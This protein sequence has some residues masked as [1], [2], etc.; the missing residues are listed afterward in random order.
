MAGHGEALGYYSNTNSTPTGARASPNS[1]P[2]ANT[3][4][5][6]RLHWFPAFSR[7]ALQSQHHSRAGI[8]TNADAEVTKRSTC[9]TPMSHRHQFNPNPWLILTV[10]P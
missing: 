1:P 7:M 6:S 3:T 4:T 2:R 9:Q 8:S 5:A 10:K